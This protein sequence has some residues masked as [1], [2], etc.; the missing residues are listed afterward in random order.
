M[1]FGCVTH[2]RD[3]YKL[4]FMETKKKDKYTWDSNP[5]PLYPYQRKHKCLKY[6]EITDRDIIQ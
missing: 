5:I 6:G 1:K 3:K 4:R 2:I